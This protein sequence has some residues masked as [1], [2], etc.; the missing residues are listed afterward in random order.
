[1]I[2]FD[3]HVHIQKN[4]ALEHLFGAAKAN[5]SKQLQQVSPGSPGTFFLL[6][7]EAENCHCF[8]NLKN[9][10]TAAKRCFQRGWRITPTKE[11]ESLLAVHENWPEDRIFLLGGRQIVTTERLE[12]LALATTISIADDL[13]LAET[14][15]TIRHQGG[16]AVLPWGAG[17]WLGKRGQLVEAFLKNASP[18]RLFVGDNGG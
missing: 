11:S 6:L 10:A 3:A 16:L 7:S 8:A 1:M 5:F 17:K 14:V 18:D 9:Q 12:V 4:F 15:N 13:P 2:L